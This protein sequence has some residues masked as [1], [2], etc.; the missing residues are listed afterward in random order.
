MYLEANISDL[1]NKVFAHAGRLTRERR[2]ELL[3]GVLWH[4]LE[5]L[6]VFPLRLHR[7]L[8][9]LYYDGSEPTLDDAPTRIAEVIELLSPGINTWAHRHAASDTARFLSTL[10]TPRRDQDA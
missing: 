8:F 7:A 4:D 6:V 5:Q 9:R 1:R 2:H 10:S 3:G